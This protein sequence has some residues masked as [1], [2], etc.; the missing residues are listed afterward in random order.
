MFKEKVEK[1]SSEHRLFL[2]T[3]HLPTL[4][5]NETMLCEEEELYEAIMS[6][7]QEKSPGNDGLTNIFCVFGKI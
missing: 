3:I 6:M 5:E 1:I 2:E 4:K 7:A